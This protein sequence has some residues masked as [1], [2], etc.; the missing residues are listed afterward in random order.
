MEGT[1]DLMMDCVPNPDPFYWKCYPT[2]DELD[3]AKL[4]DELGVVTA[5]YKGNYNI[6]DKGLKIRE[7]TINEGQHKFSTAGIC[8]GLNGN[9]TRLVGAKLVVV[10]DGPVCTLS[11]KS[12]SNGDHVLLNCTTS[13]ADH[14]VHPVRPNFQIKVGDN[15]IVYETIYP[16]RINQY[17]FVAYKVVELIYNACLPIT[18]I[19]TFDAPTDIQYDFMATNQPTFTKTYTF[20][21]T[22]NDCLREGAN[23]AVYEGAKNILVGSSRPPQTLQRSVSPTSDPLSDKLISDFDKGIA[24]GMTQYYDQ[25]KR[26]LIILTA[27]AM[28]AQNQQTTA[29]IYTEKDHSGKLS[30]FKVIVVRGPPTCS[31]SAS[32]SS[33]PKTGDSI[34]LTCNAEYADHVLHQ[35]NPRMTLKLGGV[36]RST[37]S[38]T[39]T[40]T[41]DEQTFKA[42]AAFVVSYDSAAAYT[43]DFSFDPPPSGDGY[44]Y[45]AS[46]A[47]DFSASCTF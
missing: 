17:I 37:T 31:S 22:S 9:E 44:D 11:S 15:Y 27:I 14:S 25:N 33:P 3:E 7:A 35:I 29:G 5:E 13:Y 41:A 45:M 21:A 19:L 1:K 18:V 23:I 28:A 6:T 8:V 36:S 16:E 43:C 38:P 30:G 39:K 2:S 32:A 12:P 24:S 10:R 20:P 4:N 26:G 34:T 42:T 40:K 46:N 47:P